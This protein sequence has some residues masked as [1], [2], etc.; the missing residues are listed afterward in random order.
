[1]P[2]RFIIDA[3][4]FAHNAG[5]HHGKIALSELERLQDYLTSGGG[6]LLYAITG[7][8]DATARPL[9][10]IAV[11][12]SIN[13]RCQRCLGEYG[14]MLDLQVYLLLA[15]NESELCRLD[16][17]ESVECVLATPDMDVVALIED[18]IIL[19]LPPSPRHGEDECSIKQDS[20]D[21]AGERSLFAALAAL[22]NLH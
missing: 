10:K 12:G 9:L 11:Q 5:A 16:E 21:T 19:S 1:M 8:V 4:D 18:E 17:D 20:K 15:R 13:L 7:A 2:V 22:K 3:L 14:Y 6:E